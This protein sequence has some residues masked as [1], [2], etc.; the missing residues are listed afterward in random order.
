MK[1]SV[2]LFLIVVGLLT[3]ST[4]TAYWNHAF[5]GG[6]IVDGG[7]SVTFAMI[8][9]STDKS[10]L[11]ETHGFYFSAHTRGGYLQGH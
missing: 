6:A 1:I 7:T 11:R 3:S 10:G 2:T 4:V 9:C 8:K 5:G